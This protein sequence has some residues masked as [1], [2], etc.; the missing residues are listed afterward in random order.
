MGTDG[1]ALSNAEANNETT[2]S[3]YSAGRMEEKSVDSQQGRQTLYSVCASKDY[4]SQSLDFKGKIEK[5]GR[6]CKTCDSTVQQCLS[7]PSKETGNKDIDYEVDKSLL[8]EDLCGTRYDGDEDTNLSS[9]VSVC[10][11]VQE[12]IVEDE[13]F[14]T[15]ADSLSVHKRQLST[16]SKTGSCKRL[17]TGPQELEEGEVSLYKQ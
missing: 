1:A 8:C 10:S 14:T 9:S 13:H 12:D 6:N 3:N 16:N 15:E 11:A 7:D 2:D 17:K 4:G 5:I